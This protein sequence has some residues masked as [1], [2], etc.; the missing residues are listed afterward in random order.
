MTSSPYASTSTRP[1]QRSRTQQY[2]RY[3]NDNDNDINPATR[4]PRDPGEAELASDQPQRK[5][6]N[7]QSGEDPLLAQ[8]SKSKQTITHTTCTFTKKGITMPTAAVTAS[9]TT[10]IQQE[11]NMTTSA[12]HR[13]LQ[14]VLNGSGVAEAVAGVAEAVEEP[15]L[16][17][18]LASTNPRRTSSASVSANQLRPPRLLRR[19]SSAIRLTTSLEGKATVILE[20]PPPSSPPKPLSI[21]GPRPARRGP[22]STPVDS[23]LWEF[24]CDNQSAFRSPAQTP[25]Q[26]SE[27]T[28]ALRLLR[29][30]RN[31]IGSV[32]T[33]LQTL[34][35][36]QP[37]AA[38][39]TTQKDEFVK[40]KKKPQPALS[41]SSEK[42]RT[43]SASKPLVSK[44]PAKKIP[45]KTSSKPPTKKQQQHER[46]VIT[47]A[48]KTLRPKPLTGPSN[49]TKKDFGSFE[50]LDSDK[51][52]HPPGAPFSPPS[53]PPKR[54][55]LGVSGKGTLN[56]APIR[57]QKPN[58]K[59]TP[60][61]RPSKHDF[62]DEGYGA[63][64]GTVNFGG[65]EDDGQ[66]SELLSAS[67]GSGFGGGIRLASPRR[68][69]ELECVENLLSLR[70]G[71]WR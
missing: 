43:S 22:L 55:A 25:P 46:K 36:S 11:M 31:T 49:R 19:S 14:Y 18:P 16:P 3:S 71:T 34:S 52:N 27:A 2:H 33:L 63:S 30:R 62:V 35:Q 44:T 69:D 39:T 29:T 38:T 47:S 50:S 6:L 10:T 45:F 67:Q 53:N 65:H 41:S 61:R 15:V 17:P 59:G 54:R 58:S 4:Q 42:K 1:S 57:V 7:A 64:Q 5:Q 8:E 40:P 13:R 56:S 24:C 68:V 28:Q 21:P 9:T 26:P 48:K 66:K 32:P 20:D 51:E 60:S 23:S 70:G 37:I 12:A